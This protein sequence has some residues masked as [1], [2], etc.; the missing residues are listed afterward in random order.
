MGVAAA[1]GAMVGVAGTQL[2]PP[3]FSAG[4]VLKGA[5]ELILFHRHDDNVNLLHGLTSLAS[6]L[7]RL[8]SVQ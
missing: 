5:G 8:N 2:G 7:R 3:R 4:P 6:V 1:S